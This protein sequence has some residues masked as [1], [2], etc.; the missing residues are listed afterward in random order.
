MRSFIDELN[1]YAPKNIKEIVYKNQM[2]D[3][4]QLCGHQAFYRES[5]MGHFTASACIVN[6]EMNKILLM[7][8]KKLN[9]W[10]QPGGHC[11]GNEN[12]WDVAMSEAVE[13]T[14]I[15]HL[16]A[17]NDKKIFDIDIHLIP[18]NIKDNAHYHFDIRFLLQAQSEVFQKNHESLQLK[19]FD[20]DSA[21]RLPDQEDCINESILRMMLKIKD[22]RM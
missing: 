20:I 21:H 19:W 16:V 13:E 4:Y 14:G 10:F 8:H 12:C 2:I 18:K 17:L 22:H 9:R 6:T 7:H 5:V 3:F 11:D 1:E 15:N